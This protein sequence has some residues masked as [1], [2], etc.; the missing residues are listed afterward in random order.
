MATLFFPVLPVVFNILV[1]LSPEKLNQDKLS[2]LNTFMY[3]LDLAN[4]ASL[5]NIKMEL[6]KKP[7]KPLTLGRSGTQ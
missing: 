6:Q 2:T 1:N 7:E 3:L 5:N 4:K